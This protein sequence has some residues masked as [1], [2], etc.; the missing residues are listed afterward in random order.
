[1]PALP[2]NSSTPPAGDGSCLP[3]AFVKKLYSSEPVATN[4]RLS[5]PKLGGPRAGV[6]GVSYSA[7]SLPVLTRVKSSKICQISESHSVEV[8]SLS[9]CNTYGGSIT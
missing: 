8:F 2:S 9:G 6:S 3:T 4:I 7:T 5:L 1:M